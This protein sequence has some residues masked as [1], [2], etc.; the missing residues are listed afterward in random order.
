V[1]PRQ[2]DDDLIAGVLRCPNWGAHLGLLSSS[3]LECFNLGLITGR[4]GTM[5]LKSLQIIT[6]QFSKTV[7]RAHG[8]QSCY[9]IHSHFGPSVYSGPNYTRDEKR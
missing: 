4:Y 7:G 2:E 5:K 1:V 3:S 9:A 6:G 8:A